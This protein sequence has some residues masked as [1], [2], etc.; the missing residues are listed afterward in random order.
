MPEVP[1]KRVQPRALKSPGRRERLPT[2][3][4]LPGEVMDRG[5]WWAS[6]RRLAKSQT[7]LKR[8]SMHVGMHYELSDL[9][10]DLMTYSWI[11]EK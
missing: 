2:P 11:D 5:G 3:V 4:C 6:V 1:E 7:Q 10:I 9:N 8:L